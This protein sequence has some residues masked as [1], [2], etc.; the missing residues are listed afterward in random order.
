MA[1]HSD[2]ARTL[3]QAVADLTNPPTLNREIKSLVEAAADFPDARRVL[4]Y[5]TAPPRGVPVP[6]GIEAVPV[7]R[8]LYDRSR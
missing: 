8:W 7:W 2:G 3:V 4:L 1:T 5:E 6:D